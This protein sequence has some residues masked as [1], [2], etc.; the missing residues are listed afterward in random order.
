MSA[1]REQIAAAAAILQPQL[2]ATPRP[3]LSQIGDAATAAG[4][5]LPGR[6]HLDRILQQAR[7][8]D[9]DAFLA[10]LRAGR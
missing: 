1:T 5:E 4:I 6:W 2:T 10:D 3:T 8:L 7:I 9:A